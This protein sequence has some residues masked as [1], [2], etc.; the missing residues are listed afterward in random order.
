MHYC[1]IIHPPATVTT[2]VMAP[3]EKRVI[4]GRRFVPESLRLLP[5]KR[6]GVLLS[7]SRSLLLGANGELCFRVLLLGSVSLRR[8]VALQPA[9]SLMLLLLLLRNLC[10]VIR[11]FGNAKLRGKT[12]RSGLLSS[13]SIV[14]GCMGRQVAFLCSSVQSHASIPSTDVHGRS[15]P[16]QWSI[17]NH[18]HH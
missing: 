14:S 9:S 11:H 5:D 12:S 1:G 3:G 7:I 17:G 4:P 10:H 8:P 6:P 15:G 16:I 2:Q 18:K 13:S